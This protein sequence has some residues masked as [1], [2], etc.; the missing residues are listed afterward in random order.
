MADAAAAVTR[1]EAAVAGL[2]AALDRRRPGAPG[3]VQRE[4]VA[5]LAARLDAALGQL[6]G[7]LREPEPAPESADEP[8]RGERLASPATSRGGKGA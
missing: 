8:D 3:G 6:R 7:A 1:L 2:V 5:A 4:A